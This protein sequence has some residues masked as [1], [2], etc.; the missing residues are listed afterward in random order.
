[1][2]IYAYEREHTTG[3]SI[4][5]RIRCGDEGA[6]QPTTIKE[7]TVQQLDA[8]SDIDAPPEKVWAVITDFDSF[9]EWNPFI[10]KASGELKVG[11]R[12]H[13]TLKVPDM[14]PVSFSPKLLDVEPGRLMRWKG[15]TGVP[16]FFDGRHALSVEP[17][18]GGRSRFR[19]HED[20]TGVGLPF[21]GKVM[22]RTQQGFEALAAA[23]KE[24]AEQ[25]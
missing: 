20:V 11:E 14:K 13:V 23:V 21:L 2:G 8:Y 17:L 25:G 15:V 6:G 18:E 4:A 1:L 9:P 3:P 16:G 22:R 5:P 12:L 24:R 10:I 19:T 7:V